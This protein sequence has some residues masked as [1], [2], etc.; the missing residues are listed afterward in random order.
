MIVRQSDIDTLIGLGISGTQA[1]IILALVKSGTSTIREISEL[2]G[3]ARPDTYRA[4][5]EL[6]SMA[7]I[8]KVVS[9]P[10]RYKPLPLHEA[11]SILI[12]RR[13]EENIKLQEK[14]GNLIKEY[15]KQ[16]P[17]EEEVKGNQ[18][19]LVPI[20][21]ASS[22][23]A[24]KLV[25]KT[26]KSIFLM[27]PQQAITGFLEENLGLLDAAIEKGVIIRIATEYS[28]NISLIKKITTFQKKTHVE[29]RFLTILPISFSIFDGKEILLSATAQSGNEGSETVWTNNQSIVELA[30]N[31]FD[32]AWFSAV[33]PVNQAFKRD[34]RQFDYLFDN[35]TIG[36]AYC[37]MIFDEKGKIV[38]YII[39]KVNDAFEKITKFKAESFTLKKASSAFPDLLK[40]HPEII[41][42]F[43]KVTKTMKSEKFESFF[44]VFDLW[45]SISVYS[46]KKG[47][48][49]VL[50]EDISERKK[51]EIKILEEKNRAEQYLNV[52]AHAILALDTEGKIILLNKKGYQIL[53]YEEGELTGKNWFEIC[54]PENIRPEI[55]CLFD[56]L[57][58]G[59]LAKTH[60]NLVLTKNGKLRTLLWHNSEL[61]DQDG[62]LI[63]V[64][65]SGEDITEKKAAEKALIESESRYRSF[66]INNLYAIMLTD[67]V[68]EAILAANPEAC[69]LFGMTENELKKVGRNALAVVDENLQKAIVERDQKGYAT[70][71]IQ[72][73][74]KDGSTF[75]GE[76]SSNILVCA[77]GTKKTI[78]AI[79]DLT[80]GKDVETSLNLYKI[81][82][83]ALPCVALLI[84]TKTREI[85]ASN[86]AAEEVGAV[87]GKL[88]HRSWSNNEKP[89]SWCLASRLWETGKMQHIEV[90]S[91]GTLWDTYWVP[92]SQDLYMHYAFAKTVKS[93]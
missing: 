50:F 28:K 87:P 76:V 27:A 83:D 78:M 71:E 1:K 20:G 88:C 22:K 39:L 35:M 24:T 77:D 68:N 93:D 37:K 9:T 48:C 85:V 86:K 64:L 92:V 90:K 33:E 45:L 42:A 5:S 61:K 17:D 12:G 2:S 7:L 80:K 56:Q 34:K 89:C 79:R 54:I 16:K 36:F 51:N 19:V 52:V 23:R 30:Q 55:S 70:A 18:F 11:I 69:R 74:R 53:G 81:F 75:F 49:V 25:K 57:I 13:E 41:D 15:E 6:Q 73:R 44:G 60:E 8:E 66:F 65:S 32:A 58:K 72:F 46:P 38:D 62:K 31:Y 59:K 21:A 40:N 4:L 84:R 26:E 91:H 63:G 3:V 43:N 47:Y 82:L 14:L 10:S 29:I 67:P